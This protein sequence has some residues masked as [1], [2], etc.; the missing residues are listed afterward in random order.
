MFSDSGDDFV[1]NQIKWTKTKFMH[2]QDPLPLQ[3][4]NNIVEPVKSFVYLGSTVTDNR[5]RK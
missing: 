2:G 5:D 4:G 1:I 3:L